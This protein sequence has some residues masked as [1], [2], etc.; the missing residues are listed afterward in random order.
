MVAPQEVFEDLKSDDVIEEL[1][2]VGFRKVYPVM[3]GPSNMELLRPE[4]SDSSSKDEPSET[5]PDQEPSQDRP[6][7]QP[8]PTSG[9][10]TSFPPASDAPN[11]SYRSNRAVG[12]RVHRHYLKGRCQYGITCSFLR[13]DAET[14]QPPDTSREG[15]VR[16]VSREG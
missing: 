13:P 15:D 11:A 5:K 7:S 14:S 3:E 1:T 12:K 4:S 6:S 8:P 2:V 10:Q 9:T 16:G